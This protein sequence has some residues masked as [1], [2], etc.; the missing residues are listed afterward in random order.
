LYYL[1]GTPKNVGFKT[2]DKSNITVK[3]TGDKPVK[4]INQVVQSN[5]VSI[6][7]QIPQIVIITAAEILFSITGYEFAYSQVRCF[8]RHLFLFLQLRFVIASHSF[9]CHLLQRI[10]RLRGTRI[11]IYPFE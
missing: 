11:V 5:S 6:L 10:V 2:P 9:N 4:H 7:W 3:A 1:D 8:F